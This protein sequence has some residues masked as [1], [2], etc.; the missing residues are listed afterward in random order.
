MSNYWIAEDNFQGWFKKEFPQLV[1]EDWRVENRLLPKERR[2]EMKR[3]R[4]EGISSPPDFKIQKVNGIKYLCWVDVKWTSKIKNPHNLN[5]GK[6]YNYMRISE[7]THLP[8]YIVLFT[9]KPCENNPRA[10]GYVDPK[11]NEKI[12]IRDIQTFRN[13]E[14]APTK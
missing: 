4:E 13:I 11:G 8:A 5:W 10:W 1:L 7:K 2:L 6:Y 3:W 9:G 14:G 12:S